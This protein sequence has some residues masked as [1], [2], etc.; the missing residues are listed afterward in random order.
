MYRHVGRGQC[1]IEFYADIDEE[2]DYRAKHDRVKVGANRLRGLR[3]CLNI[4]S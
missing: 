2:G 1:V 4:L 3:L